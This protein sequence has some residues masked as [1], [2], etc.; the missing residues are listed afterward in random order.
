MELASPERDAAG[1]I[2][3]LFLNDGE[4]HTFLVHSTLPQLGLGEAATPSFGSLWVEQLNRTDFIWSVS[5]TFY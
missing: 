2:L 5:W 4:T 3:V 1:Y